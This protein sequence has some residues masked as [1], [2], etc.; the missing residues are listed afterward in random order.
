MKQ[1]DQFWLQN[2]GL[3]I[4]MRALKIVVHFS[5]NAGDLLIQ[6]P[7][8]TKREKRLYEQNDSL[9]SSLNHF[10]IHFALYF[11]V[12][13]EWFDLTNVSMKIELTDSSE[14]FVSLL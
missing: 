11:F 12:F 8:N 1:S 13:N 4:V 3:I 5:F 9:S 14:L 7:Q 10:K 2:E 6:G